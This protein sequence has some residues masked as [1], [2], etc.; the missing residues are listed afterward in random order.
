ME[1]VF[2]DVKAVCCY[3]PNALFNTTSYMG[4]SLSLSLSLSN[5]KRIHI[6]GGCYFTLLQTI[7]IKIVQKVHYWTTFRIR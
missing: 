4:S 3:V 5:E 1:F 6:S 2:V 7:S